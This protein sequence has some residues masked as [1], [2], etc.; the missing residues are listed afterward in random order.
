M[1]SNSLKHLGL[2]S[3]KCLVMKKTYK[4][5][6]FKGKSKIIINDYEI[7]EALQTSKQEILNNTG[8]WKS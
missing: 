6:Y 4:T 1:V 7:H 3:R 8:N 5:G 2:S